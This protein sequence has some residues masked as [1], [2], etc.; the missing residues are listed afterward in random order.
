MIY[1]ISE[2]DL[3]KGTLPTFRKAKEKRR[4]SQIL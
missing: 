3:L 4:R 1:K 2:F